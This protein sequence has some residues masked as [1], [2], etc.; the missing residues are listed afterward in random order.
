MAQSLAR[1][2][3]AKYAEEMVLELE[4]VALGLFEERGVADVTVEEIAA[5]AGISP[6]TFY[7]HFA[8][9][10]DIFQ[11]RIDRHANALRLAL[12]ERPADEPPVRSLREALVKVVTVEDTALRR[13]WMLLV[14][15]SPN[16]VRAA[17]GGV[18]LK[19][20]TVMA[21]FFGE[22]L[23][24]PAADLV[25]A[26]LSAAAG[27]VVFAANATWLLEGG[28][29]EERLAQALDVLEAVLDVDAL[30]TPPPKR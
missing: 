30:A 9:K 19:V 16:L 14:E 21:E 11:V 23:S 13:R 7:R 20:N 12:A 6:R 10:D 26:M 1:D 4:R 3:R 8:G 18:H 25:P 2:V 24:L 27:G 17:L 29:L 22:R 28:L 15:S 5:Q